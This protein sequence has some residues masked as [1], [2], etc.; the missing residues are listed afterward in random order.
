VLGKPYARVARRLEVLLGYGL[1]DL[2]VAHARHIGFGSIKTY[3]MLSP[4]RLKKREPLET[5]RHESNSA[6][7]CSFKA[8]SKSP[9]CYL[10]TSNSAPESTSASPKT[11]AA[12]NKATR[13][14]ASMVEG[15]LALCVASPGIGWRSSHRAGVYAHRMST[16]KLRIRL[17]CLGSSYAKLEN[18]N[19]SLQL[20]GQ[21]ALIVGQE[22]RRETKGKLD[23]CKCETQFPTY[24]PPRPKRLR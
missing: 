8:Y 5:G 21:H 22:C 23:R 20:V 16:E 19:D 17:V 24:C 4:H 13:V 12:S 14:L 6:T 11:G 2:R 9:F 15:N 10:L 1:I 18:M 3:L 7:H